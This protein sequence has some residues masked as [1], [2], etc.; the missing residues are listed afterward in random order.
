MSVGMEAPSLPSSPEAAIENEPASTANLSVS[1]ESILASGGREAFSS[2][3]NFSV[4]SSRSISTV[5]REPSLRTLP[6]RPRE[7]AVL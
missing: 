7:T 2:E 3:M 5:T 4:R 1:T 6:C